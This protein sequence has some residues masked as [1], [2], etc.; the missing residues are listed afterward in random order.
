MKL[1]QMLGNRTINY[2]KYANGIYILHTNGLLFKRDKWN[3]P[4]DEAVGVAVISDNCKFVIAPDECM[5]YI[6]WGPYQ[7]MALVPGATTSANLD[8]ALQDYEGIRNTNAHVAYFGSKVDYAAG[9]CKQYVFKNGRDDRRGFREQ[10]SSI[11]GSVEC[12]SCS[13]KRKAGR[14]SHGRRFT[15]LLFL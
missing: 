3:L 1:R 14:E 12:H 11:W 4:N 2:D 9:W 6:R 15:G 13:V 7:A 5:D 10:K 8:V